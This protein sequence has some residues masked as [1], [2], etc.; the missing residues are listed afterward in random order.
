MLSVS[1][2]V[3]ELAERESARMQRLLGDDGSGSTLNNKGKPI[4]VVRPKLKVGSA[5]KAL[6]SGE[7]EEEMIQRKTQE[8]KLKARQKEKR[9]REPEWQ[10]RQREREELEKRET[11]E[12]E[13]RA[14]EA[15]ARRSKEDIQFEDTRKKENE[16]RVK[17]EREQQDRLW[18]ERREREEKEA[19]VCRMKD[20]E[21]VDDGSWMLANESARKE[22]ARLRGHWLA[23]TG[24][25]SPLKSENPSNNGISS[26][27]KATSK[28]DISIWNVDAVCQWLG[29]IGIEKDKVNDCQR[30]FKTNDINGK[31]LLS[32]TKEELDEIGVNS[33][34]IKKII[35]S[36]VEQLKA[37]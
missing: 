18:K 12:R 11:E 32:L 7:T 31:A 19:S 1:E 33:L 2:K 29:T 30:A 20:D 23:T 16:E 24:P 21:Q 5:E 28:E 8:L 36:S 14:R 13:R 22:E 6:L 34:G 27:A 26:S 3:F 17:H 9:E 35:L 4:S 10:K 25:S 37:K 15:Y